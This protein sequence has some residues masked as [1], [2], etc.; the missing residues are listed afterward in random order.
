MPFDVG[1]AVSIVHLFQ[2]MGVVYGLGSKPYDIHL[3][4]DNNLRFRPGPGKSDLSIDC[5]GFQMLLDFK[6]S[7]AENGGV[8]IPDGSV[9]QNDWHKKQNFKC[10]DIYTEFSNDYLHG[11]D[12]RYVYVCY[13]SPG[14]RGETVGHTWKIVFINNAWWSIESCGGSGPVMRP[15]NYPTLARIVTRIYPIGLNTYYTKP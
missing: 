11:I 4:I 12:P 8:I 3:P 6:C 10:H 2:N 5:S 9:N 7:G 1:K 14:S 13:C 15:Y